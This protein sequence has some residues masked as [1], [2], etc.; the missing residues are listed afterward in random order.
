MKAV[1]FREFGDVDTLKYTDFPDPDVKPGEVLIKVRACALNHLDIWERQGLSGVALPH[2]SGSDVSGIVEDIG[3]GVEGMTR[4]DEILVSPGISC[5]RCERCLRGD[6]NQCGHYT[7][8]G[9]RNNGGYAEYV[10]VPAV[11]VIPKPQHLTFGEAASV[12]LVFLTA[13]HMLV[14]RA[15]IKPGDSVL[16]QA[17]G[18]GV[19]I[20]AIQIAKLFGA[21]V[22]TTAGSDDKIEKAKALGADHAVNYTRHDF[23]EE[24]KRLTGGQGVDIV[25]DHIGP[26]V[27]D[28]SIRS[29]ARNGRLVTCGST[30]GPSVGFDLRYVFSRHLSLLGSYMG[31]KA[32]LLELLRFVDSG[33]LKPVVHRVFKLKDAAMAQ[34]EMLERKNFGKIVLEVG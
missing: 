13:W 7:I 34:Q 25:I 5:M 24:V 31:K 17:G 18:S 10:S 22:I 9:Y 15:G 33:R 14:G 28:K 21:Y 30:S 11:N 4:G 12:P 6:D 19:G 2:I 20:A 1:V 27:W 8:L 16:V 23:E 32:E 3:E 26:E 29:L